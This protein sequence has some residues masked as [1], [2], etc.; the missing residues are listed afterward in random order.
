MSSAPPAASKTPT[1]SAT[2]RLQLAAPAGR[3]KTT[4]PIC[5]EKQNFRQPASFFVDIVCKWIASL[6]E[7]RSYFCAGSGGV[8]GPRAW[9]AVPPGI[10]PF[11]VLGQ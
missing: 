2:A 6:R 11:S 9:H 5:V 3:K 7:A 4:G 10:G 8:L 1:L